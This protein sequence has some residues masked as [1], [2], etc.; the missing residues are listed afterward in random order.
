MLEIPSDLFELY[1]INRSYP[2][3]NPEVEFGKIYPLSD[4]NTYNW[5]WHTNLIAVPKTGKFS[6]RKQKIS[7][8]LPK[9]ESQN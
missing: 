2:N 5:P 7:N 1:Q 6:K 3:H 9:N 8:Y 4:S